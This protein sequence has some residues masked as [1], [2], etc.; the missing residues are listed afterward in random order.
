MKF[1]VDADL[2][3]RT[4]TLLEGY[5]HE[6]IDVRDIGLRAADDE[7]IAEYAQ[8]QVLGIVTCDFGFADIR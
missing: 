4:S 8:R 5:E 2:P 6:A 7:T 3:R 1:I